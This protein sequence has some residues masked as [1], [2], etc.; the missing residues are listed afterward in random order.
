MYMLYIQ[1]EITTNCGYNVIKGNM[2]QLWDF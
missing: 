2:L 1:P